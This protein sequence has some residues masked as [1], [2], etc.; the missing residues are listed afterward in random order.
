MSSRSFK[1]I[2]GST[3]L[4][5]GGCVVAPPPAALAQQGCRQFT[6]TIK[7]EGKDQTGY[8]V[9]CLQ[10]DGTWQVVT[11]PQPTPPLLPPATV[12]VPYPPYAYDPY[13]DGYPYYYGYPWYP[14][15]TIGLGFGWSHGWDRGGWGRDGW[16]R[17]GAPRGGGGTWHH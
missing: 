3:L 17:G 15:P 11:P 6:Q 13:Y 9:Q 16:N 10:P 12:V 7:V 8:G 14:G 4:A 2:L 1:L 5:L